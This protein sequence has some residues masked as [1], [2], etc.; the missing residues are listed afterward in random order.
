MELHQKLFYTDL[1]S[2]DFA[3]NDKETVVF[4]EVNLAG[5]EINF[6]Q[7]NNGQAIWRD[8]LKSD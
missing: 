4:L 1:A 8:Y 6:H 5:Q 3:I 2:W 7:F